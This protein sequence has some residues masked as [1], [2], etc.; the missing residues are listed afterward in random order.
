MHASP[1]SRTSNITV[2]SPIAVGLAPMRR[3]MI[4]MH[5]RPDG[6]VLHAGSAAPS[7]GQE[8]ST[9]E[10]SCLW[11]ASSCKVE[12]EITLIVELGHGS[13][14][15]EACSLLRHPDFLGPCH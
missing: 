5:L 11:L 2:Y 12:R 7:I 15:A 9:S 13:W 14:L 6:V 10:H 3:V 8:P 4:M 1:C